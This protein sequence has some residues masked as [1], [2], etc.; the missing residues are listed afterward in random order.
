MENDGRSMWSL[1]AAGLLAPQIRLPA[2]TPQVQ[3]KIDVATQTEAEEVSTNG[4]WRARKLLF[5]Q[6]MKRKKYD[7]KKKKRNT[8]ALAKLTASH[9]QSD[10]Y[11]QMSPSGRR[12]YRPFITK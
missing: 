8:C 4:G 7:D 1:A 10:P 12:V 5:V 9:P 11:Y 2:C 6:R 3:Q